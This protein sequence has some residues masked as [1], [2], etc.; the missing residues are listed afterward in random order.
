MLSGSCRP[1]RP[2]HCRDLLVQELLEFLDEVKDFREVSL[3][4]WIG[5]ER[6]LDNE[7]E[8]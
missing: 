3:D 8:C 6:D 1:R 7:L 2:R 4:V 5:A